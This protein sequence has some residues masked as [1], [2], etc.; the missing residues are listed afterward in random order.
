MLALVLLVGAFGLPRFRDA[1][2]RS[3]AGEA[4]EYLRVVRAAEERHRARFGHYTADERELDTELPELRFFRA[5]SIDAG[6]EGIGTTWRMT[7]TRR[8]PAAGYGPYTVTFTEQG[9]DS[10]SS[11]ITDIPSINPFGILRDTGERRHVTR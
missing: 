4:V 11:T 7:L 6:A 8:G 3:K 9:F 5:G 10:A 2:E 1:V